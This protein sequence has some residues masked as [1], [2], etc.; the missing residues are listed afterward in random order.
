MPTEYFIKVL[1]TVAN[2]CMLIFN[3][4]GCLKHGIIQ[5][6]K[7]T[8]LHIYIHI[9]DGLTCHSPQHAKTTHL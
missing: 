3:L 1:L 7:Y 5:T 6:A 4:P 2:E 9:V 8:T